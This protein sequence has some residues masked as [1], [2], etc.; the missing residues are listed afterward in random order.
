MALA[1][2]PAMR[3]LAPDAAPGSL[4]NL[5]V[6][7]RVAIR[8]FRRLI[9]STVADTGL[10]GRLLWQNLRE[11]LGE[12]DAHAG[13]MALTAMFRTLQAYARRRIAYHQPCCS[14]LT[15]DEIAV[16]RLLSACQHRRLELARGRAL[17]LVHADGLGDLLDAACDLAALWRR[18]RLPLRR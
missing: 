16:L 1:M 12:D 2:E 3:A 17:W 18:H 15:L 6:G 14:T 7:E 13:L 8:A 10:H 9:R 4:S 11:S 5:T